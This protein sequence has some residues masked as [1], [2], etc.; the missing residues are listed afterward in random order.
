MLRH[1]TWDLGVDYKTILLKSKPKL[2]SGIMIQDQ[3]AI[4]EPEISKRNRI[5]MFNIKAETAHPAINHHQTSHPPTIQFHTTQT[6]HF[7]RA[8]VKITWSRSVHRFCRIRLIR[9]DLST[10][11]SNSNK[12]HL[13]EKIRGFNNNNHRYTRHPCKSPLSTSINQWVI[14]SSHFSNNTSQIIRRTRDIH[15]SSSNNHFKIRIS[16]VNIQMTFKIFTMMPQWLKIWIT[17]LVIRVR[18]VRCMSNTDGLNQELKWRISWS[19]N[20]INR[21]WVII[22]NSSSLCL[23]INKHIHHNQRLD[24]KTNPTGNQLAQEWWEFHHQR[25]SEIF[26][27]Q[28]R[29]W[30]ATTRNQSHQDSGPR[31]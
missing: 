25:S 1:R 20:N 2:I 21:E 9:G 28:K 11:I 14:S 22:P 31:R 29:I 4:F 24:Q 15:S 18:L 23:F 5:R 19:N 8:A 13:L 7:P 17:G 10:A 6:I 3:I 30:T 16:T 27:Q 12:S 26:L